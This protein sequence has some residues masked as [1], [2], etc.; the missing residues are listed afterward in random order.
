MLVEVDGLDQVLALA[1]AVRGAVSA[2]ATGF[3]GVVDVVP[4]ATTVLVT[5]GE[6]GD[7]AALRQALARLASETAVTGPAAVDVTETIEIGVHYDGPDL[8]EVAELT[9]LTRRGVVGAHTGQNW[10]VAFG[11]FAP[12]FAYLSG[13]DCRLRV[14]R[15]A[16]P[17]TTVPA[18]SVALADTFSAVYPRPSPGGWQLLGHTTAV[19][20]DV[21]R[22]PPALLRPGI[23]VRFV[24]LQT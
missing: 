10:R 23:A 20:W 6:L 22:D 1:D 19:L 11:G 5:I 16:G 7:L 9:G 3:A 21:D 13:G 12:G 8:D 4:A 2:H 14:P 24:E 18:G 15:R 17:R